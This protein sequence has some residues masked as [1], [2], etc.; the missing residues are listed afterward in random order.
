MTFAVVEGEEELQGILDAPWSGG[1]C[2]CTRHKER[3][4]LGITMAQPR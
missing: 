1:E 4:L 2:S 3:S